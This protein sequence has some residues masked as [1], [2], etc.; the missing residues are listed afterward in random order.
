M[1]ANAY[2][3][4]IPHQR[5]LQYDADPITRRLR[6]VLDHL[7]LANSDMANLAADGVAPTD[8]PGTF[9]TNIATAQTAMATLIQDILA[10]MPAQDMTLDK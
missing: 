7:Y 8:A 10:I 4:E 1:P 5:K 3:G 6:A 9:A 2:L